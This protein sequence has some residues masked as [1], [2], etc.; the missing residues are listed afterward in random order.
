MGLNAQGLFVNSPT[1]SEQHLSWWSAALQTDPPILCPDEKAANELL[2]KLFSS[3]FSSA[4]PLRLLS[5][6]LW[7][8]ILYSMW[9]SHVFLSLIQRALELAKH[10][11]DSIKISP[12]SIRVKVWPS[13]PPLSICRQTTQN[14]RARAL[15]GGAGSGQGSSHGGRTDVNATPNPARSVP[16]S[17]SIVAQFVVLGA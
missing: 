8:P 1:K 12:C 4:S 6:L 7:R 15:E 5:S 9:K 11:R 16:P 14:E 13:L 3:L 10:I 2:E 17:Q